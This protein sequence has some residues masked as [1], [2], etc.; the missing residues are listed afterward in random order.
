MLHLQRQEI[1]KGS[2]QAQVDL[3]LEVIKGLLTDD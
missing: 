3:Q 2:E 1:I